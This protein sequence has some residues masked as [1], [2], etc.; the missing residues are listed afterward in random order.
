MQ[1]PIANTY[2]IVAYDPEGDQLG[3]AVQS[4][5]FCVGPVVPWAEAGV[6]AVAT[7]SYVEVSYGPLGLE[8]MRAGKSADQALNGLLAS[9]PQADV[10]QVAMLDTQGNIATH[11]GARCIAAA[12][13]RQ[14]QNYSVQANLM[15]K[16]TVWDAMA[17][18]Y[19][20]TTGDLAE[21]M[22]AALDA[23]EAEGGDMRG[24]Q[25]AALLVVSGQP[26]GTPWSGRVF[27]LRVDDNPDPLIELRRLVAISRAYHQ[28]AEASELLSQDSLD[29]TKLEV[30]T[31]QIQHV[32]QLPELARNLEPLFW[33]AV[34]LVSI[35]QVEA[36]LPLFKQVFEDDPRWLAL[37]PRLASIDRI[38]NKTA[39]VERILESG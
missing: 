2:S 29:D 26:A 18:A 15:L 17:Q 38:P 9:D 39:L 31:R 19:E 13:H 36:A 32:I 4:H 25:S 24:K 1:S 8:M 33:Y 10:R 3:V 14:G 27:D 37:V 23:A 35:D 7:Q 21:R 5:Y 28:A 20:N 22:L 11:T 34:N 30:A 12:G 16:D 6:G